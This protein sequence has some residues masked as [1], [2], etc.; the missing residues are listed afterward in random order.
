MFK[1]NILVFSFLLL[2]TSIYSQT[3]INNYKYVIVPR[4]FDFL[5]TEDQYQLNS[6]SKF[7]FEKHGFEAIFDNESLPEDL[8]SNGCLALNAHVIK[9]PGL[10]KTKLYVELTNCQRQ[11]VYTSQV[12][13]S[14]EKQFKVAYNLA[15]RE[16]FE[17][18][19]SLNY[20]YE[21]INT[22]EKMVEK[23]K[24]THETSNTASVN[25]ESENTVIVDKV[26]Q[27]VLY[28]QPIESGYQLVDKTPKVVYTLIFS[29]KKDLYM[30]KGRQAT[31]Y[32]LDGKWVIAET[33]GDDIVIS[34]LNI[35]F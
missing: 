28:A 29:G 30:V 23:S 1:R 19:N 4:T 24:T 31:V 3:D 16:A 33:S 5:K 14:R 35:K 20:K 27:Q 32:K 17:S 12:G 22:E 13:E 9:D 11:V 25:L 15:L 26:D 10:F 7:L 2:A 18:F 8:I 21:P 6:L 34:T